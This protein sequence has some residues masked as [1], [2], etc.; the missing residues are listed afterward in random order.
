M[1]D[2]AAAAWFPDVSV[3]VNVTAV[4]PTGK[5]AGALFVMVGAAETT[6]VAVAPAR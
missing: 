4:V 6:S 3:A 5:A 1:T 2:E